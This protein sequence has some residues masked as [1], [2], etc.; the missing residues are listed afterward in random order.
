MYLLSIWC[1]GS[2]IV[3]ETEEP[4]LPTALLLE[5]VFNMINLVAYAVA[6]RHYNER[7]LATRNS[8]DSKFP[9]LCVTYTARLLSFQLLAPLPVQHRR[10]DNHTDRKWAD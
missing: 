3:K 1:N 10:H 7:A 2:V 5:K 9:S 6:Y 8:H 4:S